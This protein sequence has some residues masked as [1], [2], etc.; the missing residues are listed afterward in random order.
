MLRKFANRFSN[1]GRK[2]IDDQI[3]PDYAEIRTNGVRICGVLLYPIHIFMYIYKM[4]IY[5]YLACDILVYDTRYDI[6]CALYDIYKMRKQFIELQTKKLN[7]F[8]Y[9]LGNYWK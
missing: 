6:L 5:M 9:I 4:Y 7:A 1:E 8:L 2:K 3:D